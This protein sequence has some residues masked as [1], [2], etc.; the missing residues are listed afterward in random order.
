MPRLRPAR[1]HGSCRTA[2]FFCNGGRFNATRHNNKRL[3]AVHT[4]ST[5]E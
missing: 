1:R 2:P 4:Q 5:K 3:Q